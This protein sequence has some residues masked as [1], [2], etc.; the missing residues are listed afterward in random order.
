MPENMVKVFQ[1]RNNLLNFAGDDE[2]PQDIM[3]GG[4]REDSQSDEKQSLLQRQSMPT[5][6]KVD[7]DPKQ[8]KNK[9]D[10]DQEE[11]DEDEEGDEEA[12]DEEDEEEQEEDADGQEGSDGSEEQDQMVGAYPSSKAKQSDRAPSQRE[13]SVKTGSE[14]NGGGSSTASKKM[15]EG[16]IQI[17]R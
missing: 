4:A 1:N 6:N 17:G 8:D 11:I 3:G 10:Q 13:G 7:T 15:N 5:G 9:T 16:M 2:E 14:R 12:E